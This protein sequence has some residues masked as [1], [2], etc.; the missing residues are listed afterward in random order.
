[1]TNFPKSRS[2]GPASLWDALRD[3]AD[4]RPSWRRAADFF[5]QLLGRVDY[6]SPYALFA[7][8]LGPLGGR[9][10][11]FARAW[12]RKPRNRSTNC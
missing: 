1:M 8:A 9:A 10:R 3:R 6:V 2:T 5:A 4:E 11:L 12:D 7:E